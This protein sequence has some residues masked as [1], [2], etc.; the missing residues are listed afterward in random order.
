MKWRYPSQAGKNQPIEIF[1]GITV[2]VMS[3]SLPVQLYFYN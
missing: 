1:V 2:L 3:Y